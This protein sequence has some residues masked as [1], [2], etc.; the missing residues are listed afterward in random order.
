M[1]LAQED[2]GCSTIMV[3]SIEYCA[4]EYLAGG[5]VR[6]RLLA[7]IKPFIGI[8]VFLREVGQ[9][10]TCM[11]QQVLCFK[12]IDP[13]PMQAARRAAVCQTAALQGLGLDH[14][15]GKLSP[16]PSILT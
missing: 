14:S 1:I 10:Q 2:A 9:D 5:C 16:H 7:S 12:R 8:L 11:F 13:Y 3:F 6:I 15:V 4:V